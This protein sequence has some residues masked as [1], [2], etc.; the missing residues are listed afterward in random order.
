[1]PEVVDN[2]VKRVVTN[3]YGFHK[4]SVKVVTVDSV[5]LNSSGKTDYKLLNEQYGS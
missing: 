1:M 5:P 2:D 4:S 3:K